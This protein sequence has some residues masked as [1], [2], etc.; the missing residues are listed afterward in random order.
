MAVSYSYVDPKE[1]N[2]FQ[3]IEPGEGVFKVVKAEE[4]TS[5]AGNDMMVVTF[6][7]TDA[8]GQSTLA[9]E[10]LISSN[11]PTQNKSTA[12]KVYNLLCG[13]GKPSLYGKPLDT[14]DIVGCTGQC[15]I[16]TQKSDDPQYADKSVI[17]KY[18]A[19]VHTPQPIDNFS[20]D[21]P[22]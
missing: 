11:D 20:D 7:L 9:N 1:F 17:S 22:F 13:I 12:T 3:V 10:Y 16:K 18:I 2:A 21:I 4:K 5:R 6:R 15:I 19:Q 14:N 8:R